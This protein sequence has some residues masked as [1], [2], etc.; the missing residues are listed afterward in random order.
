MVIKILELGIV[1]ELTEEEEESY[2]GGTE[3]TV[4]EVAEALKATIVNTTG[5]TLPLTISGAKDAVKL[6]TDPLINVV[7]KQP[8][9]T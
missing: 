5:T 4:S 3:E 2:K 1:T 8:E 7:Q 6:T 9:T